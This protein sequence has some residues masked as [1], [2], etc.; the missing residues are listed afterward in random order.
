MK[1]HCING[2]EFTKENTTSFYSRGYFVHVC[3]K[4]HALRNQKLRKKNPAQTANNDRK[5]KLKRIFGLT[6]DQYDQMFKLQ[7]GLCAICNCP[8]TETRNGKLIYLSVDHD[9]KTGKI[10]KLLCHKCNRA[11]GILEESVDLLEKLIQYLKET[12]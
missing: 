11:L 2:H 6:M 8:E 3:K 12:S 1:T 10:R 5:R 9:H 7:N 4:C